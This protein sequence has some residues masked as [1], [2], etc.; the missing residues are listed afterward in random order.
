MPMCV[1]LPI[2]AAV[3]A[4]F[5][6]RATLSSRHTMHTPSQHCIDI[7][8]HNVAGFHDSALRLPIVTSKLCLNI[9]RTLRPT[10]KG[11]HTEISSD[12]Y[13]TVTSATNL[14]TCNLPL[15]SV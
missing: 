5:V 10:T 1:S 6:C 8:K 7:I 3:M 14:S 13:H 12:C 11:I 4:C 2:F 15:G 9:K